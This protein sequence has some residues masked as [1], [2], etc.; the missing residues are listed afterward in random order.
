M[1]Q[2]PGLI[3]KKVISGI[4]FVKFAVAPLVF[5]TSTVLQVA[6]LAFGHRFRVVD[7]M[8]HRLRCTKEGKDRL[9]V[10]VG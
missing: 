9:E 4:T 7:A 10:V 5:I 6:K 8:L 3:S 1:F 2:Q